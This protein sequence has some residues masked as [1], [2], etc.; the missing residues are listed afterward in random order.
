MNMKYTH[1]EFDGRKF[2]VGRILG[3]N[4]EVVEEYKGGAWVEVTSR[5][6]RAAIK[7]YAA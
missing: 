3:T 5:Q 2:R 1:A 7:A 4:L 6:D